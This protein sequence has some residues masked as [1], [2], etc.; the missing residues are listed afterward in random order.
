MAERPESK[1]R[2]SDKLPRGTVSVASPQRNGEPLTP[3]LWL[4]ATPIGNAADVTLRALDVLRR[5]D[6][7][8]CED[9]RRTRKLMDLHGVSTGGRRLISYNDRNGTGRRPQIMEMLAQGQSVA[10]ASDAGTPLIAD[11]GYRLVEAAREAGHQVHV[12][13]G[14][15]AVLAALSIAGLPTDR[16]LFM[17]FLPVKSGARRR[18]LAEVV[19]LRSTLVLFESP[20]RLGAML[21]DALNVLGRDRDCAVVREV[22]KAYEE[23]RRGSLGDLADHYSGTEPRGEIVVVV[24]P[25][26]KSQALDTLAP[27]EL[28]RLILTGLKTQSVKDA[29]RSI[30]DSTGAARRD[31]YARAVE[32]SKA[33]D[34][35]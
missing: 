4:V 7:L 29:A 12:A 26:D 10:Y 31:I 21:G 14:A 17:G 8:A 15:S 19:G 13:P 30:S 28:D 1:R 2:A 34:E 3:G 32:L 5:A 9:T 16:F 35:H 24:G 18:E 27:E 22:T 6:V 20:R 25:P 23:V 33:L 11:P